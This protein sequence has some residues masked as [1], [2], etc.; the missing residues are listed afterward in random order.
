M[1]MMGAGTSSGNGV[2][3]L[4]Y[5][6]DS[7]TFPQWLKRHRLAAG[8]NQAQAARNA[9]ISRTGWTYAERGYGKRGPNVPGGHERPTVIRL[10][11]AVGGDPDEALRLTGFAGTDPK[12]KPPAK[13][14]PSVVELPPPVDVPVAK[15]SEPAQ[16]SLVRLL[17]AL[18]SVPIDQLH[19]VAGFLTWALSLTSD[20]RKHLIGL[21]QALATPKVTADDAVSTERVIDAP[22]DGDTVNHDNDNGRATRS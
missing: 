13:A 4:A 11:K 18:T 20:Q 5:M 19:E 10:A 12:T 17:R 7:E 6:S 2:P 15:V 14:K 9:G 22:R 16:A 3:M 1:T 8:L 21:T